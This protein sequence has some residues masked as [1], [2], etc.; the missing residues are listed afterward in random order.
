[1]TYIVPFMKMYSVKAV[2][3]MNRSVNDS[4]NNVQM[5]QNISYKYA[6]G[7]TSTVM[8]HAQNLS[9]VNV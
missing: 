8:Q 9:A 6:A 1:M 2:T 7:D 3:N 5:L 4:Q